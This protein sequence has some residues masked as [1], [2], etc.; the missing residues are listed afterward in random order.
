MAGWEAVDLDIE[1][2]IMRVHD[3]TRSVAVFALGE[4]KAANYLPDTLR[5]LRRVST[6]HA[7]HP[8][9]THTHNT[10]T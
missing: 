1:A 6:L 9:H 8:T 10:R 4:D 3:E 2:L 5:N 7:S